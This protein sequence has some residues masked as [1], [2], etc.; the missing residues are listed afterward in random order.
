MTVAV[1]SSKGL[2]HQKYSMKAAQHTKARV[3]TSKVDIGRL[4]PKRPKRL[5][6][7]IEDLEGRDDS[8]ELVDLTAFF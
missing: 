8:R 1:R 3:D 2:F 7:E 4:D 6:N 5:Y